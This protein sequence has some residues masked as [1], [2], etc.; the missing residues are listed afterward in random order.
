MIVSMSRPPTAVLGSSARTGRLGPRL[1][2]GS[3]RALGIVCLVLLSVALGRDVAALGGDEARPGT[4]LLAVAGASACAVLVAI[5]PVVCLAAV[6]G[7]AAAGWLPVIVQFG[8]VD[9]TL[10]DIF[11]VG[12]VIGW[13][14]GLLM[15]SAGAASPTRARSPVPQLPAILFLAF[16]GLTLWHVQAVDPGELGDSLISWLR[17]VQTASLAWLAAAVIETKR[18]LTV[19]LGSI[20]AGGSVAVLLTLEQAITGGGNPLVDRYGAT[21]SANPLGLVS[22]LL[23]VFAACG[24]PSSRW[25][26]RVT[27]GL[28]GLLGLLLAKSVGAFIATGLALAVWAAFAGRRTPLDRAAGL[29]VA[30]AIAGVLVVALVQ[31]LRPTATP[32]DPGFRESSTSQ[33]IILG[34]AGLEVFE[35]NPVIGAGWHRSNSPT[36]I[37]DPEIASELRSRFPTA[38]HDF[39]PDVSPASVHNTYVGVLADLGLIGFALFAAVIVSI[40]LGAQRVLERVR[41]SDLRPLARASALGLVVILLWLNDNP[42]QGGQLDTIVLAILAGALAA[43]GKQVGPASP[44]PRRGRSDPALNPR[45]VSGEPGANSR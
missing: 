15:E 36:V 9:L 1:R 5:G 24:A 28:T 40:G 16:A 10:A 31:F 23:V 43:V 45:A 6:G 41:G 25:N 22:G 11:Y 35:R 2:E 19:V 42:I 8:G 32:T 29:L 4:V 38:K 3:W 44:L 27:L 26:I 17:L 13:A 30:L 39:F 7:L 34:A 14:S 33:R 37:G 21:L 12:A 20:A 18:D